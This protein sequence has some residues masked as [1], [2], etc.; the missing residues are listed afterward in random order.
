[1]IEK[2]LEPGCGLAPTLFSVCTVNV[3]KE[4]GEEVSAAKRTQLNNEITIKSIHADDQVLKS[5]DEYEIATRRLNNIANK[6]NLKIPAAKKKKYVGE[7][8]CVVMKS[9]D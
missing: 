8:V 6:Y 7:C 5:E 2:I 1:V 4:R 3:V 9:K